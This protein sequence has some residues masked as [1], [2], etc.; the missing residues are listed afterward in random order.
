MGAGALTR[1]ASDETPVQ[2]QADVEVPN[3]LPELVGNNLAAEELPKEPLAELGVAP[4]TG[5]NAAPVDPSKR[6]GP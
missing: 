1:S 4:S 2:D 5:N 6:K 3:G